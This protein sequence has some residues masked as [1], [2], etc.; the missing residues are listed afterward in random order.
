MISSTRKQILE[1]L[2]ELSAVCPELRFGQM[3]ANLSYQARGLTNESIW[4]MEDEELLVAVR[5]QLEMF[6][7]RQVTP[8]VSR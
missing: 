1:L 5:E 7:S 3:V 8:L 6:K 4:E 2:V